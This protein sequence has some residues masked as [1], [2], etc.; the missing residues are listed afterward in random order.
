MLAV[1]GRGDVR[2]SGNGSGLE[3]WA[4]LRV[5]VPAGQTVALHLGV[6]KVNIA[7]VS[8]EIRVDARSGA[9]SA[10]AVDGA[11]LLNTGSGSVT[12]DGARGHLRVSTG[13]GGVKAANLEN[14]TVILGT[15]EYCGRALV[16]AAALVDKGESPDAAARAVAAEIRARGEKMPGF[17]HPLHVPVDPRAVRI[18]A[19]A[20]SEGIAGRHVDLARR[21]G[22][23][24]AEVFGRELP[25]NISM[26]I[27]VL[28]GVLRL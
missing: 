17:G 21:F 26:P 10:T 19:L 20:E 12:V 24:S 7:N 22:P 2:V 23:A 14:G 13:S 8:G 4:D 28:L 9:V 16:A 3:A 5:L 27:A 11:L 15:P 6:G 25:M 18:L 1:D